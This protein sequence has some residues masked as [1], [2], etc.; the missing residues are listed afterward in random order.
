MAAE[1]R[2]TRAPR[3]RVGYAVVLFGAALFVTS[4]F[5]PYYG[6]PGGDP[7]STSRY[8]Q[9]VVAQDGGSEFGAILFLFGGVATVLV[10]AVIGLTRGERP[11]GHAFLAGAVA[12][13]VTHLDRLAALL[14]Q[15]SG[16][17]GD[18]R[19]ALIGDWLL[20]AGREYR[21]SGHWNHPGG[22]SPHGSARAGCRCD[23]PGRVT[24]VTLSYLS[25][26]SGYRWRR[27]L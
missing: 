26:C 14:G 23:G 15:P 13:V 27:S 1:D 18:L 17:L 19:R 4:C 11:S 7:R 2:R 16:R 22:C 25:I 8:D 24:P 21:R 10:V 9:L 20:A 5:L 6:L 12:G 3:S